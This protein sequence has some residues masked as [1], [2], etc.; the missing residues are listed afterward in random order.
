[1]RAFRGLV[2]RN[3]LGALLNVLDPVICSLDYEK[4]D[5]ATQKARFVEEYARSD[6][7]E[8]RAREMA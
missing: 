7:L 1:M 5:V 2:G 4:F 8:Q 3:G 6:E